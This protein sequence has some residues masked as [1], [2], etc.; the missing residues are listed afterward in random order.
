MEETA[1]KGILAILTKD[2]GKS[3]L[4]ALRN[5]FVVLFGIIAYSV[6]IGIA[7]VIVE[8][9]GVFVAIVI[10]VSI[11]AY[12]L[13]KNRRG[14]KKNLDTLVV[15]IK[16]IGRFIWDIGQLIW[17]LLKLMPYI[18]WVIGGIVGILYLLRALVHFLI[19]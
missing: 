10:F 19:Y 16:D 12:V 8:G 6:I 18:I 5:F 4:R 14:V 13:Y 2:L 7:E 9:L 11:F 3:F 1:K 15:A 17:T